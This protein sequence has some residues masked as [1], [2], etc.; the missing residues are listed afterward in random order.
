MSNLRDAAHTADFVFDDMNGILGEVIVRDV[1]PA[2]VR[3]CIQE[4]DNV[5]HAVVCKVVAAEFKHLDALFALV[6]FE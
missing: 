1:K 4:A 3:K 5:R 2:Q 6:G